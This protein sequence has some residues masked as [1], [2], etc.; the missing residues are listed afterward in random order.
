V[1]A[2]RDVQ[3]GDDDSRG[4]EPSGA[5]TGSAHFARL[6]AVVV[7]RSLRDGELFRSYLINVEVNI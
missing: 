5:A 3:Y 2:H 1:A 7:S 4:G 6:G